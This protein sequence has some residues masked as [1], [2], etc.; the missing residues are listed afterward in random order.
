MN[1]CDRSA[2]QSTF[3]NLACSWQIFVRRMSQASKQKKRTAQTRKCLALGAFSAFHFFRFAGS[4]CAPFSS[5]GHQKE[6]RDANLCRNWRTSGVHPRTISRDKELWNMECIGMLWMSE[7]FWTC[8]LAWRRC[9]SLNP[10]GSFWSFWS[11]SA[12]RHLNTAE[13]GSQILNIHVLTIWWSRSET[14]ST[15]VYTSALRLHDSNIKRH[16]VHARA[17]GQFDWKAGATC[18][19]TGPREQETDYLQKDLNSS[20]F[21]AGCFVQTPLRSI[22]V[23]VCIC[24]ILMYWLDWLEHTI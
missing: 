16:W 21:C 24:V 12:L 13:Q 1:L 7:S 18:Q 15:T 5:S 2:F 8:V 14:F 4:R 10:F 3:L 9:N 22:S 11:T 6:R 20:R 23:Y 17:L 19:D